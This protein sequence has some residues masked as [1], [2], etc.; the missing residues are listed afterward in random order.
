MASLGGK[1]DLARCK[2]N[3]DRLNKALDKGLLWCRNR[4]PIRVLLYLT[5]GFWALFSD[6]FGLSA[7][8]DKALSEQLGRFRAFIQPV[9][10]APITVV[11]IDYPSIAGLHN[12]GQGWMR[13]NDWPL[14][15]A[16][17]S[18]ILRDLTQPEHGDAA[19]AAI[20]Y[21]I[22][23]ERPRTTSGDLAPLGRML[24]RLLAEPKAP[25]IY[26]AGGGSFVPMSVEAREQLQQ[27][28]LAVSAWEGVGDHYPLRAP[29]GGA[30][31]N[32]I[33]PTAAS[34]L[35]LD[36]CRAR[37]D[38]CHWIE[39]N[40]LPNLSLQWG[41][42]AREDCRVGLTAVWRDFSAILSRLV[43][44]AATPHSPSA[45]CMP[46][47]QVRLSQLYGERPVGLRPPHLEPD[48]PFVVLVGNVMPSLNDYVPSPL[49]GQVAGVYLHANALA[50]LNEKGVRY[51]HESD[52]LLFN[53]ACL[54]LTILFCM[55]GQGTLGWRAQ[56]ACSGIAVPESLARRLF[57]TLMTTVLYALLIVLGYFGF[58][59]LSQAPDGWLA[60]IAFFPFL[61]EVVL[62]GESNYRPHK[63]VSDDQAHSSSVPVAG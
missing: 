57:W 2:S 52:A 54:F 28:M 23:F 35:Y 14:T 5:L 1:L 56:E 41:A 26:L 58:Y 43:G 18:R 61:R 44:R 39:T 6:P 47:H 7:A 11:A 62:A 4:P 59:L 27:P 46:V 36:L 31:A 16:D 55:W 42:A 3:L 34:A 10:L 32:K 45:T 51:I 53:S 48:E 8:A 63:E 37:G 15:Y 19:P 50:N 29:L 38:D 24:G 13:A 60:L 33:A 17:H 12:G 9:D 49:Y 22:L 21:D 40:G 25:A 30:D 20:F